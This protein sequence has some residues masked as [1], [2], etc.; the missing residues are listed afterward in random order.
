MILIQKLDVSGRDTTTATLAFFGAGAACC[1]T[2]VIG[3][4]LVDS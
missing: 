1:G 4:L 2:G 3:L